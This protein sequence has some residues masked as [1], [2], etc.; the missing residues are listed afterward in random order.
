MGYYPVMLEVTDR[1]CIVI[2]GGEVAERKVL[3]LLE[4]GSKVTV[5]SP[6]LTPTLRSLVERDQINHRARQYQKGD[7]EGAFLAIVATDEERVNR[8]ASEEAHSKGI[9]VNVV[10]RPELCSFIVPA[11][12]RK[13]PLVVAVSTSGASPAMAARLKGVI[14]EALPEGLDEVLE[15]LKQKRN[16]ILESIPEPEIRKAIFDRLTS[17]QM[18]QI[19][20]EKGSQGAIRYIEEVINT[21]VQNGT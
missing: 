12:I 7:L 2:G 11:V 21:A 13:G 1:H 16:Q 20:K 4:A 19:L 15:V 10:D 8:A 5:I 14:S 3:T 9:P 6:E 18:L 17:A